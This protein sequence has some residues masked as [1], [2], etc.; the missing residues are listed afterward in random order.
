MK[1]EYCE[2]TNEITTIPTPEGPLDIC[3]IHIIDY[4]IYL[5]KELPGIT[6]LWDQRGHQWN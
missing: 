3:P 2:E 4:L 6:M 5:E 1:C